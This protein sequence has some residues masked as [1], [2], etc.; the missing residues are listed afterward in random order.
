MS[1][2]RYLK[3]HIPNDRDITIMEEAGRAGIIT[4]TQVYKRYFASTVNKG[5]AVKKAYERM[6]EMVNSGYLH[7]DVFTLNGV[8]ER[9]YWIERKAGKLFPYQERV[10]F[11]R[12]RPSNSELRHMALASE[13]VHKLKNNFSFVGWMSERQLKSENARVKDPGQRK[14]KVADLA[15]IF[16]G[17]SGE[18]YSEPIEVDSLYHGARLRKSLAA[19][20]ASYSHT[21]IVCFSSSRYLTVRRAASA[22]DNLT[23][24]I[25]E[26]LQL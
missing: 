7:T 4:L 25:F 6:N 19:L 22:Y 20:S 11:V 23:V 24:Q 2:K 21:T 3:K 10:T 1:G 17:A 8:Q 14:P 16:R 26:E 5:S 15:P 13:I 12:K 9:F 18:T